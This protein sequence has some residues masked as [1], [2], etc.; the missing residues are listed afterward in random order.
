MLRHERFLILDPRSSSSDAYLSQSLRSP[1]VVLHYSTTH[2]SKMYEVL[3]VWYIGTAVVTNNT[4][5]TT[6]ARDK[7]THCLELARVLFVV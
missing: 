6:E 4:G 2:Y 7:D 3:L 5:S 1:Y